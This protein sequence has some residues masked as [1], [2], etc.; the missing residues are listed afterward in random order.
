MRSTPRFLLFLV[1]LIFFAAAAGIFVSGGG[2]QLVP[3]L[4]AAPPAADA[5]LAKAWKFQRDGWTYVH[6]EGP[7]ADIGYQHGA[8]LSAEIADAFSAMKFMDTRRTKRDWNFFRNTAKNILWPH[9]DAEYQQELQ[10]IADGLK[11][12]GVAVPARSVDVCAPGGNAG[13]DR[14]SAR[15]SAG[16]GDRRRVPG[17]EAG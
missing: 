15:I 2:K 5:R 16:L 10:G 7:P 4:S 12:K 11:S 13:G 6:L 1:C 8:L 17:G 14:I 9:I 3:Q